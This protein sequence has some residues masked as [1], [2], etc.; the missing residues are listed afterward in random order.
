[1]NVEDPKNASASWPKKLNLCYDNFHDMQAMCMF[2]QYHMLS[3]KRTK[4]N[5]MKK[6]TLKIDKMHFFGQL[7]KCRILSSLLNT[8]MLISL[9]KFI[10][11]DWHPV[12]N[13]FIYKWFLLN[14]RY[15]CKWLVVLA[16]ILQ[17]TDKIKVQRIF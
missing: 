4:V 15:L 10:S 3:I 2:M 6:V 17:R 13:T 11:H 8:F 14:M 1:M 7:P 16:M 5:K 12:L 9:I